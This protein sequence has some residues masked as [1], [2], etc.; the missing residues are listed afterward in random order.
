MSVSAR[1][2]T[3]RLLQGGQ[4]FLGRDGV[5]S[6]V[7]CSQPHDTAEQTSEGESDPDRGQSHTERSVVT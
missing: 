2:H 6:W 1:R 4:V 3:L 5:L 7:Q